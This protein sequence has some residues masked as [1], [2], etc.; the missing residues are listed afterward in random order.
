MISYGGNEKKSNQFFPAERRFFNYANDNSVS[1]YNS[2]FGGDSAGGNI[3][4]DNKLI[5]TN[6]NSKLLFGADFTTGFDNFLI[7]Y[8]FL[9]GR[10]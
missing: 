6:D 8:V 9:M 4:S 1:A 2:F 7:G 3:V 5:L 10:I